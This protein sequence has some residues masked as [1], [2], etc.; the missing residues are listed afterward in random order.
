MSVTI[1]NFERADQDVVRNLVLEG[2]AERWGSDFDPSYNQDLIDM[3]SY[4]VE[5]H[6]ASVVV[7]EHSEHEDVYNTWSAEPA[8]LRSA[9]L[10]GLRLCRMMRLSVSK[11]HRGKGYAKRIILYLVHVARRLV[12]DKI[13]VETET[14]WVSAVNV[15]KSMDFDV[16]EAGEENVH[17]EL[18]L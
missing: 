1:R 2:L 15:Y 14:L 4:Y 16:V 6:R 11:D 13:L 7:L 17:F 3:Y 12:F 9:Q 18:T 10:S 8:A 5:H